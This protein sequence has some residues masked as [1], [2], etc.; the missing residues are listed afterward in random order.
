[1]RESLAALFMRNFG[2]GCQTPPGEFG[3]RGT[4]VGG[5]ER[6]AV[7]Q[8]KDLSEVSEEENG[9]GYKKDGVG[10]KKTRHLRCRG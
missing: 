2:N 7:E 10:I 8:Q 1:M 3:L 4:R 9:H 6:E 5:G